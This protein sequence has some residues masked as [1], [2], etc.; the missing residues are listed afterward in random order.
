MKTRVLY[1]GGLGRSGTTLT[2]RVLRRDDTW[3]KAMPP[4]RTYGYG[5]LR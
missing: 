3:R 4:R 2:E 1:V 5:F